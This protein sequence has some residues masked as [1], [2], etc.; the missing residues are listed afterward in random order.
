MGYQ[1]FKTFAVIQKNLNFQD[2][3]LEYFVKGNGPEVVFCMHG[4]SKSPFDFEFL[5]NENR[6]IISLHLFYHGNSHFPES[7]IEKNPLRINEFKD[8]IDVLLK[9]ENVNQFHLLAFSQGGRFI[10][11][12]LPLY[13]ERIKSVQLISPD[14][15]DN[16]SFYN[17]TSRRKWARKLFQSWENDP[18]SIMKFALL[19]KKLRLVRPKVYQFMENLT[20]DPETFQRAS[21]TWRG[22]RLIQPNESEIS[23]A[24]KTHAIPFK[25]IMGK[26]DQ[27]I[28]PPQAYAFAKRINQEGKVIE[29][30]CG[31][32][33]FNKKYKSMLETVLTF[34]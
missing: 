3:Q 29:I 19:G 8:L 11:S 22:F 27:V 6:T 23:N 33:F 32:D 1:Q 4:H 15:M 26:F 31:H 5:A 21:K 16:N 28:R 12:I 7:R 13:A 9:N 2:L 24:L 30:E 25:I 18:K 20:S 34:S 14:G 17:R 10:L